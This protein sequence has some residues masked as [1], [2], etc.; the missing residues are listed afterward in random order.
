MT[1]YDDAWK[2][3]V[4]DNVKQSNYFINL[5]KLSNQ[6]K[7][8]YYQSPKQCLK[9]NQVLSYEKRHNKFCGSIC[10]GSTS[11]GRKHSTETKLKI[12]NSVKNSEIFHINNKLNRT[13]TTILSEKICPICKNK[14]L[15]YKGIFCSHECHFQD[16]RNGYLFSKKGKKGGYQQG[17]GRGKSGWY[18]GI[19]CNS[20]YE[21]AWVIYNLEHNILFERNN[22]GFIYIHENKKYKYYPDFIQNNEYIEIKGFLRPNDKSKFEQFPHPLKI[23][24]GKDIKVHI[25]YCKHKYGYH[26]E[27]LYEGNPHNT[28]LNKCV[29]CGKPAKLKCCSQKCAGILVSKLKI[30]AP[31]EN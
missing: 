4:S 18:K 24:Y 9:C 6:K 30:G 22:Q 1:A 11:L 3:K 12:S 20:T 29:I 19:F 16:Q 21:L 5:K 2:K 23:L 25:D 7:E 17:S 27:E 8:L 26:F 10:S 28:K 13:Y 15:S 31:C 14:F